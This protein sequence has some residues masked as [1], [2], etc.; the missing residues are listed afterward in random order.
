MKHQFSFKSIMFKRWWML[1]FD[2]KYEKY[3]E[4]EC[5]KILD[6]SKGEIGIETISLC[7]SLCYVFFTLNCR[8][9]DQTRL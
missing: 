3:D 2:S 7:F 5:E 1:D 4:E 8:Y 9:S 6:S